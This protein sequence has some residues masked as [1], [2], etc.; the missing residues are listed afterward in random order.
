[1][2]K[3]LYLVIIMV[4]L[5]QPGLTTI[6]AVVPDEGD[7]SGEGGISE[8][9]GASEGTGGMPTRQVPQQPI[10][11]HDP[12][13]PS[14]A[15]NYS[16]QVTRVNADGIEETETLTGLDAMLADGVIDDPLQGNNRLVDLD[17]IMMGNGY[18]SETGG[19]TIQSFSAIS[20]TVSNPVEDILGSSMSSADELLG[21]TTGDLNADGQD[22]QISTWMDSSADVYLTAGEMSGS[23]AKAT[24]APVAVAH[25]DGTYDLLVRGYDQTLWYGYTDDGLYW[26]GWNNEAGGVLLSGP[27]IASRGDG[28]F[29][30]FA[31]GLDNLTYRRHWNG[32]S[33]D[34][35]WELVDDPGA[36]PQPSEMPTRTTGLSPD[37]D[38]PAAL[39]R[40]TDEMDLFRRGPDNRL[41]WR[42]FNG[43]SWDG[44]ESLK[45]LITSAP[46]AVSL[47]EDHIQ[48]F[49]IG[50]DGMVWH[51]TYT[52]GN[53]EW[54]ERLSMP[55]DIRA[56]S[57]P[58]AFYNP[59]SNSIYVFLRGSDDA[60]WMIEHDGNV[61]GAWETT[62]GELASGAGVFVRDNDIWLFALQNFG[63]IL[64][65]YFDGTTWSG[66]FNF[67]QMDPCCQN[68][69]AGINAPDYL[70]LTTGHFTG[71]GRSQV[72]VSYVVADT[73]YIKIY[74]ALVGF[75]LSERVEISS[76]D[77]FPYEMFQLFN[78]APT[79]STVTGDYDGDGTDEIA[80][81]HP[82]WSDTDGLAYGVRLFDVN[83]NPQG[84]LE[85]VP[86]GEGT[87]DLGPEL[88]Y[89][90]WEP[91]LTAGDF[92]ADGD[93]ELAIAILVYDTSD[94]NLNLYYLFQILD[95]DINSEMEDLTEVY[96]KK[97]LW[98]PDIYFIPG[99][100]SIPGGV[101]VEAGNIDGVFYN[102]PAGY[103][104]DEIVVSLAHP[105]NAVIAIDN[106]KIIAY[107][108]PG[109]TEPVTKSLDLPCGEY[110]CL[111]WDESDALVLGDF[112]R[113]TK[114]EIALL[115]PSD[116]PD[117]QNQQ[118]LDIYSYPDDPDD[119]LY[120]EGNFQR[121]MEPW[122]F[123]ELA[124]GSFT[125]ES[126]RVGPPT[127]RLQRSTGDII[128]IINTPPK[129]KDTLAGITYDLNSTDEE[130]YASYEKEIG[131]TTEMSINVY[132]NW[133]MA[134]GWEWNIGDPTGSHFKD[135]MI[136]TYGKNFEN[137]TDEYEAIKFGSTVYAINDDIVIYGFQD[138]EIWEYPV[139]DD[140]G[141]TPKN[142]IILSWPVPTD[143]KGMNF[144]SSD[145]N[146]I[147]DFWYTPEHQLNNV[148]SYARWEY[149]LEPIKTLL[150]KVEGPVG[151]N[152]REYLYEWTLYKENK[153]SSDVHSI[154]DSQ[155]EWQIGG[156]KITIN[157][158][159]QGT[160][161]SIGASM[162]VFLPYYK[163]TTEDI[164][165]TGTLTTTK[166]SG[167]NETAV[168]V[169]YN[170]IEGAKEEGYSYY[171]TP[172][173]YWAEA[174]YLVLDYTTEPTGTGFW[175]KYNLPDPA[176]VLPWWEADCPGK[177]LFSKDIVINPPYANIGDTVEITA[178]VHNFS[179]EPKEG[180]I[181]VTVQFCQGDP[182][183]GCKQIGE[184][185]VKL[186][187]RG[188]ADAN[189]SW[190]VSGSG[191][192]E[193]Y[194]L[195]DPE[196][197]I[198]EMHDEVTN[199]E[200]NNNIGFGILQV[201]SSGYLDPGGLIL[202][203]Y[204]YLTYTDTQDLAV[205]FF[206]PNGAI[207]ETARVELTPLPPIQV[208][209]NTFTRHGFELNAYKGGSDRDQPWDLEF[210]PMPG[211][212]ILN[213]SD[214]D[215]AGL[216]ENNLILYT[217]NVDTKR[218]EDAALACGEYQRY[219][220]ENWML[221]PVCK[222]GKF[223]LVGPA[224]LAFLPL[225]GR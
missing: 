215:I 161:W 121:D 126:L 1:M 108:F 185:T 174:G 23:I 75:R 13:H 52:S 184:D 205:D 180:D 152:D 32:W 111:V 139:F 131:E 218:R 24:S 220:E 18:D 53:W 198:D 221:V 176:F 133:T 54:W 122:G 88:F 76:P 149:Q 27:A 21:I 96:W 91:E 164:Y 20:G 12:G 224:R 167:S 78:R 219:P 34:G 117:Q 38:A 109:T 102:S 83:I 138:L 135:S 177:K 114:D 4:L 19:A 209:D 48:V 162:D 207:I 159:Y 204:Q 210:S 136:D 98:Y 163:A 168:R 80:I 61:W 141:K 217:Y 216:D 74:D 116:Y 55:G 120:L 65:N 14:K 106:R 123:S 199:P 90:I 160:K 87:K 173:L 175:G 50:V 143:N 156:E 26:E 57:A 112:N 94:G 95:I 82:L 150:A 103:N 9:R 127:Y 166:V 202:Y 222:T 208:G 45:G 182:S 5:V 41:Y 206:L 42:Y 183:N 70:D 62:G 56:A 144:A 225:I 170:D 63:R 197:I 113:D 89:P 172:Y 36:W 25:K 145:G 146:T 195:V 178:T 97:Q 73:V 104:G 10:P 211:A 17:K 190:E 59:G 35:D 66:W 115:Y 148:W 28:I 188:R 193:I 140:N 200:N 118:N 169:Y 181:E 72:A 203:D 100:I 68:S 155:S 2:K 79:I 165:T 86:K 132:R 189:I 64:F 44:W 40:G 157:V 67:W 128:A 22:E 158:G 33:W 3:L 58:T 29:D 46:S 110:Y 142:H 69:V 223:A 125:G 85:I 154:V 134:D 99:E 101:E 153:L 37:V 186:E 192:Q 107:S 77:P 31:I 119:P 187:G 7:G 105:Y 151:E 124:A 147:C 71:D 81:L 130:T 194:A 93:E 213:Y 16:T 30:V 11:H 39:A 6:G 191:T 137:I 214:V 49:A 47:G 201:G 129:H 8:R 92:D 43:T 196:N 60:L 15:G 51:R 179:P 212:V 84:N 171:V